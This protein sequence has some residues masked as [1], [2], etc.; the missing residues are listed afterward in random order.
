VLPGGAAAL[1]VGGDPVGTATLEL[2][3]P[4]QP[5][6]LPL[7]MDRALEPIR[8]ITVDTHEEGLWWKDE[9]SRYTVTT[10]VTNPHA[11]PVRL[12]LHDQIPVSPDHTVKVTLVA[13]QPAATLDAATGK[14][15]WSLA[16]GAGATT[17]VK[18]VYTLA[19]PKGHRLHQ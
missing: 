6:T 16:L 2:V 11:F 1:F 15:A 14:V 10:E 8:Q 19:R 7:G 4:G 17:T 13:S 5:F 9:I 12:R 3:A 18:L